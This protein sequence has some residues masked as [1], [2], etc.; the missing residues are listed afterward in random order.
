MRPIP[1]S[2]R[3][4]SDQA[5][6]QSSANP[7]DGV[8]ARLSIGPKSLVQRLTRQTGSPRDLTHTPGASDITKR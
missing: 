7:A 4:L 2:V 8:K 3:G 5:D 6:P 1:D